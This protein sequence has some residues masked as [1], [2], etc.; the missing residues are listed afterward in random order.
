MNMNQKYSTSFAAGLISRQRGLSLVELMIALALSM[1]LVLAV[2]EVYVASR[3]TYRTQDAL[4]RLQE[5]ARYAVET[6]SYDMRMAG[7]V[8]C[9]FDTTKDVNVLNTA[10]FGDLF[11]ES[12]K[13]FEKGGSAAAPFTA[14]LAMGDAVQLF[15]ASESPYLVKDHDQAAS[16]F[17]FASTTDIVKDDILVVTDCSHAAVFQASGPATAGTTVVHAA[18]GTSPGNCSAKLGPKPSDSDPCTAT[19][20]YVTPSGPGFPPGS[21]ILRVMSKLYYIASNPAGEPA[22]YRQTISKGLMVTEEIVEGVEDMQIQYGVDTSADKSAD[23]YVDAGGVADWSQ[24]VS[25]RVSLLMRTAENNVVT[26]PQTYKFP[27]SA[28]SGTTAT[29]R[30]IRQVFTSTIGTRSRL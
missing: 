24:V 9:S 16:T 26:E 13:G 27:A 17:N 7:Q 8:G 6:M 28:T 29:D 2:G 18:G 3:Q 19:M 22:L 30:R 25:M 21:R 20:D 5:N 23:N 10:A 12:L 1:I 4:S 15:R 11:G 14:S